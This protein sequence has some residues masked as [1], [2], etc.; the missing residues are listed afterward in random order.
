MAAMDSDPTQA[1]Q[2]VGPMRQ[3]TLASTLVLGNAVGRGSTALTVVLLARHLSAS[4]FG[5]LAFALAAV[6]ILVAV[7]DGGFSRLIVRE[8]AR[9][10]SDRTTLAWRFLL[11]RTAPV[12]LIALP[13]F[14]LATLG[15]F[16]SDRRFAL[17]AVAFLVFEALAF[18]FENAA[19]GAEQPSRFVAGQAAGAAI[20]VGGVFTL[21]AA[22]SV[23]LEG[24]MA[25]FA[26]ASALKVGV[27]GLLWGPREAATI[28]R[29]RR[30]TIRRDLRDALPFLALV[31]ITT[32]HY[33]LGVIVLYALKGAAE[34]A[35]YAAAMRVID[36]VGALGAIL[37]AAVAPTF[38]RAHRDAPRDL[39]A[40][41]VTIMARVS[42]VVVPAALVLAAGSTLLADALF[43]ARYADSV[44]KDLRLLAP[45]AAFLILLGGT[46]VVVYMGDDTRGAIRLTSV[47]LLFMAS[48]TLA[49][50]WAWGDVGASIATS[51][52]EAFSFVG[53]AL[54]VRH[55][56]RRDRAAS[57]RVR[58]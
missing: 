27:S 7:A 52:A 3:R 33:R 10:D 23:T 50:A 17:L 54:F 35:P 20:L 26:G 4:D 25:T 58:R 49:L 22:D 45:C 11:A 6:A 57:Q 43:G 38:S 56:H 47:N 9:A 39:W 1:A 34:T 42:L 30:L 19:V 55:R 31:V 41:W 13:A 12:V 51:T 24:A 14:C 29:E 40:M 28:L 36:A 18:G 46:S 37:F 5:E 32:A 2:E 21:I 15:V 48:S 44:G 8:L 16:G 53:F